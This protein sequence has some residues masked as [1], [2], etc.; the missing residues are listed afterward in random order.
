MR[1][2]PRRWG[3]GSSRR[4][5]Q[6][7]AGANEVVPRSDCGEAGRRACRRRSAGRIEVV[8]EGETGGPDEERAPTSVDTGLPGSPKTSVGL[9]RRTRAAC[10]AASR[11]P[12]H[13]L[14]AELRLDPADE[15][16][17]ADRD[18]PRRH[19]ESASSASSSASR[20]AGSVS[21]AGGSRS[22]RL[23]PRRSA[24][25]HD[26]RSTGR[27][28]RG[29]APRRG[30]ATRCQSTRSHPRPAAHLTSAPHRLQAPD[31]GRREHVAGPE[32]AGPT[33]HIASLH[34]HVAPAASRR[35]RRPRAVSATCSIGTT[36]SAPSGTTPP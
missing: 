12:E 4:L 32:R 18:S 23:L 5:R 2:L 31:P 16:V 3:P 22:T 13:L 25:Q 15:I 17:R 8:L 36:A 33:P 29:R 30:A 20:C 27:S 9:A 14:D 34:A 26:R 6:R 28:H 1:L 21:A 24:G 7:E 35:E 19:D 10:P 11:P